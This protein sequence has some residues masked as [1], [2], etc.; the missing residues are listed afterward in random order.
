MNDLEHLEKRVERVE[1]KV[2]TLEER[3]VQTSTLL[4]ETRQVNKELM[5]TMEGLKE[6]MIEVSATCRDAVETNKYIIAEFKETSK[7][8]DDLE[9]KGKVDLVEELKKNVWKIVAFIVL[10]SV[11]ILETKGIKIF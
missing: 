6:S 2:D 9:D 11:L 10:G 1:G 5:R 7:R 3:V 4:D 8:V